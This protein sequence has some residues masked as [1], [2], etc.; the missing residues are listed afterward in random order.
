MMRALGLVLVA[1][2]LGGALGLAPPPERALDAASVPP[3]APLAA[4]APPCVPI[5]AATTAPGRVVLV[6]TP[7]DE[8][9]YLVLR[10]PSPDALAPLVAVNHPSHVDV[11]VEPGAELYY[12]VEAAGVRSEP[13]VVGVPGAA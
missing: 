6:W 2:F 4:V 1:A 10:G 12:A 11:G 13:I 8:P 9:A 7:C 3:P 5:V